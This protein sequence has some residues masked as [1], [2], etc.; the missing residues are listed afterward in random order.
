MSFYRKN[1]M[2]RAFPAEYACRSIERHA[3]PAE[4]VCPGFSAENAC[5]SMQ[6]ALTAPHQKQREGSLIASSQCGA[7]LSRI[8]S[9]APLLPAPLLSGRLLPL[10]SVFESFLF[11]LS[12]KWVAPAAI[13]G[14]V[15]GVAAQ[16]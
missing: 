6:N 14:G 16:E 4:K 5:R 8:I 10:V 15:L 3:K 11:F 7:Q 12:E 13:I 1:D 2:R 9:Q